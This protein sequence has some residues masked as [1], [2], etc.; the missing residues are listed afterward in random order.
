MARHY[1]VEKGEK[2]RV[3]FI[4]RRQSYHGITL[5]ALSVGGRMKDRAPFEQMLMQGHHIAPCYEYRGR[6]PD[7]RRKRHQAASS[8]AGSGEVSGTAGAAVSSPGAPDRA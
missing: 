2:T 1:F 8:G 5:G 3:N 6:R 7:E 4:S